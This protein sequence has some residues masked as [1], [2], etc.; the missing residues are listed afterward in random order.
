MPHVTWFT[1][2][3]G[4]AIATRDVLLPGTSSS[5]PPIVPLATDEMPFTDSRKITSGWDDSAARGHD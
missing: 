2:F 1:R 3:I 5:Q 4:V